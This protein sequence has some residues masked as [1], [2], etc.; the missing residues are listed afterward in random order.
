[1]SLYC[2][3]CLC[4]L[5]LLSSSSVV[6]VVRDEALAIGCAVFGCF[7]VISRAR[8]RSLTAR[9]TEL[10]SCSDDN[11]RGI[12]AIVCSQPSV[13]YQQQRVLTPLALS[14]PGHSAAACLSS[15]A[16]PWASSPISPM[17]PCPSISLPMRGGQA[18]GERI[19]GRRC[20][21]PSPSPRTRSYSQRYVMPGR[22]LACFTAST[23]DGRADHDHA[24]CYR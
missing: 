13:P 17:A 4:R 16:S 19:T 11:E 20:R 24:A 18:D 8:A 10:T 2:L 7:S 6:V 22:A 3:S 14:P 1:M 15:T 21:S 23:Q 5:S 12:T 9:S